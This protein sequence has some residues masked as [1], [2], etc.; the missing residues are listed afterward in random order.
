MSRGLITAQAPP[1]AIGNLY[2]PATP[3]SVGTATLT[4]TTGDASNGHYVPIVDG[5]TMIL[6]LNSDASV[7]RTITFG[8]VVDGQNRKGDITAYSVPVGGVACFG[9]FKQAYWQQS[10]P[11]GLYIDVSHAA[12]LLFALTLP[13]TGTT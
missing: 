8:S 7:A 6:A 9:P 3:L 5:K 10:S 11:A 4:A 13:A 12:M 1:L 2:Y